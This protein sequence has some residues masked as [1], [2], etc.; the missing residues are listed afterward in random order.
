MIQNMLFAKHWKPECNRSIHASKWSIVFTL[1]SASIFAVW[2][3]YIMAVFGEAKAVFSY[4][5]DYL[6]TVWIWNRIH[7]YSLSSIC[8][9]EYP[10]QW[11]LGSWLA[12]IYF[13]QL[14]TSVI[15][16]HSHFNSNKSGDYWIVF[17]AY[18]KFSNIS[19]WDWNVGCL[20]RK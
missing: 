20:W 12:F 13:I 4:F 6:R 19:S 9:Q 5:T 17:I 10:K 14:S 8:K 11:T 16:S 18:F 15:R 2:I 7:W 3:D 1:V